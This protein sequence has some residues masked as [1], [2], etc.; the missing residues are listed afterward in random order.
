M[1]V[2]TIE[3]SKRGIDDIDDI[4]DVAQNLSSFFTFCESFNVITPLC[5]KVHVNSVLQSDIQE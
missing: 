1:I 2:Q 4:D 3:K 5:N